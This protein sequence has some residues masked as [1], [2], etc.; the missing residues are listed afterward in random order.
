MALKTYWT[1][2]LIH[3]AQPAIEENATSVQGEFVITNQDRAVGTQCSSNEISKI[4]LRPG[5]A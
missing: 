1:E 4:Y 2:S 3:L 5:L